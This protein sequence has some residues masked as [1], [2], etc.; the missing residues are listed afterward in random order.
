[1]RRRAFVASVAAIAVVRAAGAQQPGK[2]P[3]IGLLRT[4]A[5]QT[6]DSAALG[7]R[8]GLRELGYVDGQ[9]VELVF[10]WAEEHPGRLHELAVELVALNVDIIV[11]GAEQA[12]V[13]AKKAT[14]TVPIVMGASNDPV[15]AGLVASLARPGGNVTGM[16]IVSP[17]LSRKRLELLKKVLPRLSTVAVLHNP[18]FQ[19]TALDL[20][21]T[22]EAA[23]MLGLTLHDIEIRQPTSLEAAVAAA[24]K[25]ADA[26]VLLADPF[27]T[28]QRSRI[29]AL[30]AQQRLP[31][32]YYWREFVESE[33]LMS[34]GPNL[35]DLY[36]RAA[37][38]VDKI[39]KSAKPGDL[40]IEQ[41]E[42]FEC[43]INVKTARALN[44]TMPPS[45]LLR[46]DQVI[47]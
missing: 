10:R 7:F 25:R 17:E 22:R 47:E 13:A 16:T 38:H 6:A 26:I 37:A 43:V 9:N 40:P 42:K 45:L 39:L 36:R 24:G 34:Y 12:I 46:A 21:A 33:G 23:R 14:S 41:P 18:T 20:K 3:K 8:Q 11:T 2:L 4:Q 15:G 44:V 32:M 5:R 27:F 30:A 1:V 31:A 29:V 28:A 35:F 19:G